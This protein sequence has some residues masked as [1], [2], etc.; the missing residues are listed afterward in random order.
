MRISL[1]DQLQKE[2]SNKEVTGLY[3]LREEDTVVI[4]S[5]SPRKGLKK[6]GTYVSQK[7]QI[8]RTSQ[9]DEFTFYLKDGQ[10]LCIHNACKEDPYNV[11]AVQLMHYKTDF[12]A[13]NHGIIDG[14]VLQDRMVTVIGLGSVGATMTLDLA[15]CGVE[16]F[17][18]VDFDTV[19]ISN[20]C[21]S[22]YDLLDVG[23]KKTEALYQKIIQINPYA[24][25]TLYDEDILQ[26]RSEEALRMIRQSDLIV[27]ATDSIP[28]KRF[29]N[30]L[31]H[32]ST[33]V[34]Y[35]SVYDMGVGGD[36]LYTRPGIPCFECVFNSLVEQMKVIKKGDWEYTT[37]NQ[38]PMPA[39]ISDIQVIIAR[40][41]KLGLAL[42]AEGTA[43]AFLDKVT[44]PGC[45]L[46]LVGNE[47]NAV[48]FDEPFEE[49]WAETTTDAEC[50]CQTLS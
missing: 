49:A 38:K 23:R 15:R 48:I 8:I 42:L 29:V 21:R 36:I 5:L 30:G 2:L 3:G 24:D 17:I 11:I 40:S 46:L 31:A 43:D 33:A 13:R 37:G 16:K 12:N 1:I 22:S 45:T 26:V 25:V 39:L 19:S 28:S 9:N 4:T 6:I 20:I 41:V 50:V 34:I 14:S 18:L 7:S 47:R 27:E 35:S 32:S 10:L 44:E